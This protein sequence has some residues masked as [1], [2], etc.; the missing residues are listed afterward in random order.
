[1]APTATGAGYWFV[2]SDGGVFAFG[3]APFFGSTGSIRLNAP[4]VGIIPT[5][6]GGGY[7]LVG[8]DGGV[9][10]F[11]D[12]G[13][14]GSLGNIALSAPIVALAPTITNNGYWLLGRDG[15]IY[16]FG[17][18]AYL[19]RETFVTHLATDIATLPDGTGYLVLD[20]TGG[21]WTHRQPGIAT[22][23]VAVPTSN[24]HAGARA[25]GIAITPDGAG[26]WVAWS[27]R[28]RS[29]DID[30]AFHPFIGI[31][32]MDFSRCRGVTWRFDPTNAPVGALEFYDELFDYAAR[33]TGMDFRYGGLMSDGI[34]PPDTIVAGWRDLD[35]AAASEPG[36]G[37]VLGA[38]SPIPPNTARLWLASNLLAFFPPLGSRGDWGPA[39]WGPI[40]IHELGHSL[41]LEHINDPASI[42]NP[43]NNV[44]LQWGEGD[45]TGIRAN[46][47]C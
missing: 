38:A 19:G 47:T 16:A 6:T 35:A 40:A 27:G 21:V 37:V 7:W 26:T 24:P 1:M 33:V 42:M 18:A 22:V 41:G 23:A 13:F 36:I 4:M 15:A 46:T 20:A 30:R 8:A 9:F 14:R 28:A 43:S 17:D 11:G 34:V 2:A 31:A 3:D 10:A 32:G 25:V 39:G 29:N 12:A 5:S 44:L 45:L